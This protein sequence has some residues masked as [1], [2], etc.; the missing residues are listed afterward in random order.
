MFGLG[1]AVLG[2]VG[3]FGD[4][5]SSQGQKSANATNI[6]LQKESEGWQEKMS[7]TAV[8]R[9]AADM[10]A[11]GINPLMAA[12]NP[13]STPTLGPA[14][15]GN[16]GAAYGQLGQQVS[17]AIATDQQ[18]KQTASTIALQTAQANSAQASADLTRSHIPTGQTGDAATTGPVNHA[19][20]DAE[21]R[22]IQASA[23]LTDAQTGQVATN[24]KLINSQIAN[25]DANT[26]LTN[27][28]ALMAG[29]D[30]TIQ[31]ATMQAIIQQELTKGDAARNIQAV[32]NGPLGPTIAYL[33]AIAQPAHSAVSAV[34]GVKGLY[35]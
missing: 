22:Q 32:Q 24:V 11:A 15:V 2:G 7:D 1:A 33:Q 30:Y 21:L 17:S 8:Q 16:A 18:V 27:V 13:A 23:N 34:S 12:G 14:T 28:K 5:M 4:I 10:K 3:L 6:A 9:R 19:L 31:K 29:Q 20:G 35:Q 25:T 26:A